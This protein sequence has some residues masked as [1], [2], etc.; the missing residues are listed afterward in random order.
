MKSVFQNFSKNTLKSM[1]LKVVHYALIALAVVIGLAVLYWRWRRVSSQNKALEAELR[2][3]QPYNN[4]ESRVEREVVPMAPV[5]QPKVVVAEQPKVEPNVVVVEQLKA[6]PAEVPPVLTPSNKNASLA[7]IAESEDE[8]ID[9]IVGIPPT[10]EADPMFAEFT[11]VFLLP[12]ASPEVFA[13]SSNI[14]EL[15]DEPT[16]AAQ[17]QTEQKAIVAEE[18]SETPAPKAT[19]RRRRK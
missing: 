8:D 6:K 2:L 4:M 3:V 17:D 14:T 16:T 5:E 12:T 13:N 9:P 1:A 19:V 11:S 15:P 7:N 10:L 18:E